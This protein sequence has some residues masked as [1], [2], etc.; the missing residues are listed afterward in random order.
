MNTLE[1]LHEMTDG[2]I[3]VLE[4]FTY[5]WEVPENQEGELGLDLILLAWK[6]YSS[7]YTM[8]Y[9]DGRPFIGDP[10]CN[11]QM[12]EIPSSEFWGIYEA[13]RMFEYCTWV[14]ED[15]DELY[16]R[17]LQPLTGDKL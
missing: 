13:P 16:D 14:D 1:Y 5:L 3:T 4:H 6:H 7:R 8:F 2:H 9:E 12:E 10:I 15:G 11:L 17:R